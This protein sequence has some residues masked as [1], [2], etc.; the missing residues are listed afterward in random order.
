MR[1]RVDLVASVPKDP[2]RPELNEDAWAPNEALTCF[3]V[4]DGASE[5][6]D[7]R[8]W[9]QL[10]VAKYASDPHFLPSWVEDATAKYSQ[11]V[12]F[13]SLS[14]SKQAAYERGSF[15]TLLGLQLAENGREVKVL[16]VGDS[17]ACQLRGG[18]L[19]ATFPYSS[20]EEFDARPALLS[21]LASKNAFLAE[22][23]FFARNT[24]R[25]WTIEA[26][27]V[28]LLTT[29]AVGQWL[30]RESA[31]EPSSLLA[32]ASICSDADLAELVLRMRAEQ[33]M[34]YDDSTVVRLVVESD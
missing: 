15:A 22:P 21:T 18:D 3:A 16:A 24:A 2:E 27:D 11:H 14:W 4:S 1:L 17:L 26:G 7:S 10:L 32:V 6:Y 13:D 20:A 29:D 34:R 5:S 28:L 33:R 8:A 23:D 12:D 30:L 25:T 31:N 9:A 19:V